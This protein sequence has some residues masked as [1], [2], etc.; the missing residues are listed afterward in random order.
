MEL[1]LDDKI[2][3]ELEKKWNKGKIEGLPFR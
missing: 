2:H 3:K 1:D